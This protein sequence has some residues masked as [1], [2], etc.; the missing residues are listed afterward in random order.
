MNMLITLLTALLATYGVAKLI[1]NYDG[2][3]NVFLWL[4]NRDSV[5]GKLFSCTVCLA[6]W[7]AIPVAYF[8]GF[9]V[10]G[11]LAIIGSVILIERNL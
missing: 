10:M 3:F 8:A 6:V 4:R 9:G 7:V 1:S 2:L 11:Y 5:I